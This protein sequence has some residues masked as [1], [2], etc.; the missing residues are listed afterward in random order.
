MNRRNHLKKLALALPAWALGSGPA[1]ATEPS[2]N[3]SAA[4]E[5]IVR[6]FMA[7]FKVPGFSVAFSQRGQ[8]VFRSAY[9]LA[10]EAGQRKLTVD[11]TFRIAS[12]SKPLTAVAIFGLIEQGKLKPSDKVF[13]PVGLLA[14]DGVKDLPPKVAGVT[15]HHLLTHTA[16][17]WGNDGSDPMFQ[18]PELGHA[19]LIARTLRDHPL[20]ND[21][22]TSYA[23]SNFG[24]CVLG[25]I[26]EKLTGKRYDEHVQ[27][28]V[29]DRCDVHTMKIA[30]NTLAERAKGEVAY[31]GS[32][33]EDPYNMNV[34]R[35]DAHG[36]WIARPEDLVKFLIHADGLAETP[37][38][39]RESTLKEM[40]SATKAN[41]GYA[42]GWAVNAAPN[43]W[44][45][46]SLPGT[47]T[48]AV[49]TASGMCWAGFTNARSPGISPALDRVMWDIAKAV[50][51]WRA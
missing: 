6:K 45:S 17:G 19:E 28:A 29:L 25:R 4:I 30:G 34:R 10:E 12:V 41:A 3:Q 37:D 14:L 11:H 51:D 24:Y 36:G 23:Y 49:T 22:G 46:G 43:R 16:G 27:E 15:V 5:T 40:F 33:G 35:M 50:P 32:N 2:A 26:V 44:H 18:H 9:G 38:L 31:H 42:S 8:V 7:Q 20:R 39:L 13:G 1:S 48:I 21:P 47:A